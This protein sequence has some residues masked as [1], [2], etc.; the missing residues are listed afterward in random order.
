V[1]DVSC[2]AVCVGL[3]VLLVVVVRLVLVAVWFDSALFYG[4][5]FG[6][7]LSQIG[8]GSEVISQA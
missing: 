2:A 1:D 7:S 5:I 6:R 8:G 3:L 4:T